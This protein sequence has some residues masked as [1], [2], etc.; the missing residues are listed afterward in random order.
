MIWI[1]IYLAGYVLTYFLGRAA[2]KK[3][4]GSWTVENRAFMLKF[5][6]FSWAGVLVTGFALIEGGQ[7]GKDKPASW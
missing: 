7:D 3:D 4:F 6:L 2:W 5:S 1:L